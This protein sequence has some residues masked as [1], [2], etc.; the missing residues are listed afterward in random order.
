MV[1]DY[2]AAYDWELS[3]WDRHRSSVTTPLASVSILGGVIAFAIQKFEFANEPAT[4]VLIAVAL[5][6]IVALGTT[7]YQLVRLT[8]G[9]TY[10]RIP[11]PD[12][13]L[14][15]HRELIAWHK[16]QGNTE[17]DAEAAF[18]RQLTDRYAA[19]A[20]HN[21]GVNHRRSERL[22]RANRAL[23][24]AIAPTFLLLPI[25]AWNAAHAKPPPTRVEIVNPSLCKP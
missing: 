18:E 20:A 22:Y 24:V 19:A 25:V 5:L 7:V 13:L 15:L 6:A 2:K 21:I 4:W 1:Y 23:I 10:K 9:H 17:A 12:E 14:R 3:D 16:A 8:H 11:K